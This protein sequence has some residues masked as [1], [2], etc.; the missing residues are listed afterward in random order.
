MKDPVRV[1]ATGLVFERAT[2]DLWLATRGAVCPITNTHL[3]KEEL[4]PA[5]DLR[6]RFLILSVAF[7]VRLISFQD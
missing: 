5:E 6:N 2:I 1:R 4:Q 7:S 3:D